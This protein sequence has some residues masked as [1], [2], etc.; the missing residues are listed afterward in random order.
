MI[1]KFSIYKENFYNKYNFFFKKKFTDHE[2]I[3]GCMDGCVR[4]FDIRMGEL[5]TDNFE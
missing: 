4:T 3:I 1:D 2:I 5:K